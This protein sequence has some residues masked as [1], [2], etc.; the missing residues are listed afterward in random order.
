MSF[1]PGIPHPKSSS[2]PSVHACTCVH[3][4]TEGHLSHASGDCNTGTMS[5]ENQALLYACTEQPLTVN[6]TQLSYCTSPSPALNAGE[7]SRLCAEDMKQG[8]G[9]SNQVGSGI[10]NTVTRSQSPN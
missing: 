7:R 10:E 4:A 2:A 9:P 6:V 1:H 5:H 8:R 3:D